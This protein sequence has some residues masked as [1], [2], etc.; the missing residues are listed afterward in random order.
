MIQ[1]D[2][3]CGHFREVTRSFAVG[4][5]P[6]NPTQTLYKLSDTNGKEYFDGKD[7]WLRDSHL[8]YGM[9]FTWV[10]VVDLNEL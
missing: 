3:P 10:Y 1:P 4:L 9:P 5:L 8:A 7:G 2:L 6:W